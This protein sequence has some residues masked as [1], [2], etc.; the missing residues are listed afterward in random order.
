MVEALKQ[1]SRWAGRFT[2]LSAV[3]AALGLTWIVVETGPALAMGL[4]IYGGN[5]EPELPTLVFP[6]AAFA[7]PTALAAVSFAASFRWPLASWLSVAVSLGAIAI[8][9]QYLLALLDAT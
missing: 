9:V 8:D 6:W 7:V 2:A 5:T 4:A 1:L 3:I